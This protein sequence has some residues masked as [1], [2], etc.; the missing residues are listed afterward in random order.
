M[1]KLFIL[2]CLLLADTHGYG[3]GGAFLGGGGG[4]ATWGSITGTLSNQTDLQNALNA[5]QNS[6]TFSDS[7]QNVASTITLVGD[8]ASPGAS[9]YYGTNSGS[10]LGYYSLPSSPTLSTVLTNGNNAAG[11]SIVGDTVSS[12]NLTLS[13]T[14]NGTK[15]FVQVNDGSNILLTDGSASGALLSEI[16]GGVTSYLGLFGASGNSQFL[17]ANAGNLAPETITY[18]SSGSFSSPTQLSSGAIVWQSLNSAYNGSG[19]DFG[20][21]LPCG[22]VSLTASANHTPSS[23]PTTW[24]FRNT[25]VGHATAATAVF[26]ISPAGTGG[27][28][29]QT[30]GGGITTPNLIF[31]TDGVGNIGTSGANRPLNVFQKSFTEMGQISTP[32]N[33]PASSDRY[34]F[35]SDDKL[36]RLTSGGTETLIGP[37]SLPL[38]IAQGGTNSSTALNNNRFI[39]SSGGSLVEANAV[40]ASSAV[41]SDA[42]GLPVASSTTATELGFVHGVTSSIQT[43][44][45]GKQSTLTIGNLTDAGTDGITVT[46][47][48]GAVI[49]TGTSLSQ[50]VA[51]TTHNGYLSSTDWNTFNGKQSALSGSS[52]DVAYWTSS[53]NIGA[54]GNFTWSGSGS[55]GLTGSISQSVT[56]SSASTAISFSETD[57]DGNTNRGMLVSVSPFSGTTSGTLTGAR[58]QLPTGGTQSSNGVRSEAFAPVNTS[59]V[60]SNNGTLNGNSA[61]GMNAFVGG[62]VAYATIAAIGET[63]GATNSNVGFL[64]YVDSGASGTNGSAAV[65]GVNSSSLT[66]KIA[67]YFFFGAVPQNVPSLTSVI[68]ADNGAVSA[69]IAE[70]KANGTTISRFDSVGFQHYKTGSNQQM[71]TA[72]LTAGTVTVSNS[73]VVSSSEIFLTCQNPNSGTP[74]ALYISALSANTSFTI[75]ST[76]VLDTCIVAWQIIQAN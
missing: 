57:S 27:V 73:Q 44:L 22:I 31:S 42:N 54:S 68:V 2:F 76:S 48:T 17:M 61:A 58:F 40:T 5:K 11:T 47:G 21:Q 23:M 9:V 66:N 52:G 4:T 15:G 12:G 35:K 34:Y 64:G 36:Y 18:S 65:M 74:G 24:T 38:S 33:P 30:T 49:G 51:D 45:N 3:S 10:Q 70:F 14:S 67:G 13:S 20:S 50:H 56:L 39:I 37:L 7:I 41:A 59:G 32:S 19:G 75:T 8:K 55:L 60:S 46:G 43:Q 62:S 28:Q 6:L 63:S 71:G 53:S 69:D 26:Q 29:I 25:I 16:L 1:K 72:T